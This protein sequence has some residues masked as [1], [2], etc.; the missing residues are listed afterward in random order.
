[1]TQ[2]DWI[3]ACTNVDMVMAINNC[4][5]MFCCGV[6]R[7]CECTDNDSKENYVCAIFAVI[8]RLYMNS[9][10]NGFHKLMNFTSIV[11]MNTQENVL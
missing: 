5:K 10:L 11:F 4:W 7:E 3:R 6:K 2:C 9:Q 1:M 8:I